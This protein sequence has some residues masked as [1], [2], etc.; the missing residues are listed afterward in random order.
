MSKVRVYAQRPD[1]SGY[2][3]MV[4]HDWLRAMEKRG[5]SMNGDGK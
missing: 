1:G 4:W 5:W 2:R 3:W